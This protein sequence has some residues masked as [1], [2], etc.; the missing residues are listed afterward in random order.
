MYDDDSETCMNDVPTG[1]FPDYNHKKFEDKPGQKWPAD[2][3]CRILL[4]DKAA[5]A[6][7]TNDKDL[8]VLK[9]T[10]SNVVITKTKCFYLI[11]FDRDF[12]IR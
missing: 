11:K 1:C 7:F 3:Q 4:R 6:F 9:I 5:T 12:A 10:S 2:D 8:E